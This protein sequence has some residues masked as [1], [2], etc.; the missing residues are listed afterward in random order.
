MSISRQC[1]RCNQHFGVEEVQQ[2]DLFAAGI[3]HYYSMHLCKDKCYNN[4]K[5][6]LKGKS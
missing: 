2:L 1:D 5:E 6:F 3:G 4:F